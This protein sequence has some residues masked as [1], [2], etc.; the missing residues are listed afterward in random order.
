VLKGVSLDIRPGEVIGI[1]GR[2]GSGKSTL[3]K[4]VQRLYVP[5]QGRVLV[6]GIDISLDR[7]RPAAPPDRRGAAGEPAV[8]PQRAR[9][10]RHCRPGRPAR[11][12][13]RVAQLA[14]AHDFISELPEGLRHPG[15]RAGRQPLGRA[16]PAHCHCAG[17]VHQPAH[18]DPG[19]S[20]QRAGLRSEA[21]IQRNMAAICQGRTVLIIAHRLS[22]VRHAHRIIVMDKR[23]HRR[24]RPARQRCCTSPRACMP[25]CGA[26]KRQPEVE[27]RW[28]DARPTPLAPHP[29]SAAPRHPLGHGT[30]ARATAR[31]QSRLAACGMNWPAR[32]AWP[33]KRPFC[34]QP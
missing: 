9:E 31:S 1:V 23:P 2:S 15:G 25:G 34:P 24:G 17:A 20:H 6:D 30:A 13:V 10:H 7:R 26:C 8:Q 32:A 11:G 18:P 14:G 19:R 27:R 21:I 16:A 33:T 29:P 5:E 12:V 28:H 3:T 4:L 22:A